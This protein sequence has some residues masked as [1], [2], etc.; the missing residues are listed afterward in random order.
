MRT[1]LRCRHGLY[2]VLACSW[3]D[4][5]VGRRFLACSQVEEP[6][7]F[8]YWIDQKFDGRAKRVIEELVFMNQ[9]LTELY[10]HSARQWD[11]L[12]V[13]R[14]KARE[15]ICELSETIRE[16]RSCIVILLC[17]TAVIAG[18]LWLVL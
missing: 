4:T 8:K 3:S 1:G 18:G 11:E 10:V 6:C 16:Q 9:S 14:Q 7:D 2:P 15:T 12:F 13:S 5:D 17:F